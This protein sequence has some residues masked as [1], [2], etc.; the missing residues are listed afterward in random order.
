VSPEGRN[1]GRIPQTGSGC[2]AR[3]HGLVVSFAMRAIP[4]AS[5][6]ESTE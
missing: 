2:Q 6:L 5:R 1:L 4:L 3:H